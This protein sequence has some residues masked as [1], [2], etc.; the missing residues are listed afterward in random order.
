MKRLTYIFLVCVAVQCVA[1]ET[2][3]DREKRFREQ[4]GA[5]GQDTTYGWNHSVVTGLNL[6]QISFK[7][8]ASGGENALAYTMFLN[9]SSVN[10]E[11]KIRWTN[12]YKVAFGQTRLGSQGLRK[13]D[14][15]IYFEALLVY[16]L[17]VYV[18]PYASATMRTQFAKGYTYDNLGNETA[19]SKFFDPG[20]LTQSIGVAYQP[21]AEVTTRFGVALR[22]VITS[23]F[24]AY[25]DDPATTAVEKTK[26]EGGMESVTDVNWKFAENMIFTSKLE[27]FAPFKTLD[28][29][30]VRSDNTIS[31]KVNKYVV[32]SLNV[33]FINDVT[34]TPLT[35]MKQVLSL[36]LSY[37][38]L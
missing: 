38:L 37:T 26:V 14:D 17:G 23:D 4:A 12:G 19:V 35:Q 8:W 11:E 25:A 18:N 15:E 28:K 30:I 3:A 32:T 10:N 27:T 16:K 24:A 21:V 31:A 9:G 33:Q 34:V 22:E 13:T 29:I 2:E 20:Y 36:G 5:A 7:D 6:T 1:Q